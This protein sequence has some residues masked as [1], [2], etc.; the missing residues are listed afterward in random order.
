MN[1]QPGI[2]LT[3]NHASGKIIGIIVFYFQERN[4]DDKWQ[5]KDKYETPL[6]FPKA[7]KKNLT[8]EVARHKTHDSSE[9]GPNVKFR[10]ELVG[11]NEAVLRKA[12]DPADDGVKLTRRKTD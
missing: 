1:G 2:D 3:I 8:F 9:L 10:M 7:T 5:V 12:D 4:A 6:L 11:A